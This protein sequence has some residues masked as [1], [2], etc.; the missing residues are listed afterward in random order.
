MCSFWLS[1]LLQFV[2]TFISVC[3]IG[4][5]WLNLDQVLPEV[6]KKEPQVPFGDC[7]YQKLTGGIAPLIALACSD[8][9]DVHETAVGALWNL[10]FYRENA[11]HIVQD[12]GVKPLIHLCSSSISKM[13]RFMAALALVYIFDRRIDASVPAGPSSSGSSKTLNMDGV[14]KMAL[15]HVE[16]FVTSFYDPQTFHTAAASLV[17]TALAQI[18]E[19]IRIQEA[20]HLRWSGAEINRFL[21][22]L[23]DP[24]SILKSC[25]AFALLQ[26]STYSLYP[27]Y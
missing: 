20:G 18:A 15:K 6:F 5:P 14:G 25:S 3:I 19:A 12:G 16:E 1:S 7:Q 10:A 17:P 27:I 8:I 4:L 24:S 9:E 21:R 13:A 26:E 22:M 2:E 11:L 23:R